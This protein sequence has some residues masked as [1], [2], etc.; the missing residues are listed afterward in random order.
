MAPHP[1]EL[2]LSQQPRKL[3]SLKKARQERSW[4]PAGSRARPQPKRRAPL[5]GQN[6]ESLPLPSESA[7]ISGNPGLSRVR[8]LVLG[9][10]TGTQ[11]CQA[12]P[13]QERRKGRWRGAA[14]ALPRWSR[15][16]WPRAAAGRW[17]CACGPAGRPGAE[18]CSHSVVD[19]GGGPGRDVQKEEKTR[20]AFI[21][22]FLTLFTSKPS[23]LR[24]RAQYRQQPISQQQTLPHTLWS[25]KQRG[26]L[27]K[28]Q[29]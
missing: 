7:Q 28:R 12:A 26:W 19:G 1:N 24:G 20:L 6:S 3:R 5:L 15:W 25:A 16:A 23:G 10:R 21:V 13:G 14:G 22:R 8:G 18:A 29:D 2:H 11:G 17:W 4:E 27:L 9:G